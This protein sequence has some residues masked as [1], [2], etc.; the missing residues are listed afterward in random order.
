MTQRQEF[1]VLKEY[2]GFELREYEPCVLAEITVTADYGSASSRA[3]GSLFKYISQGNSTATK[4]AMTAPVIASTEA[5]IDAKEWKVSFVM[6]A[7]SHRNDLPNPSNSQVVLRELGPEK[8]V[9]LH[10]RGSGSKDKWKLK[11]EELRLLAKNQ[12]IELSNET[13]LC[14]FDPPFKPGFLHYNEV[15][16]PLLQQTPTGI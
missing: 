8:C 12:D 5:S 4:I 1:K 2:L 3:F 10:F 6:P 9:A 15:V 14:R 13:R 11:E 7:G 16:I